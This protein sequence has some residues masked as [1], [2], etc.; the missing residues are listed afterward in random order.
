M[1]T[2]FCLAYRT[3][4]FGSLCISLYPLSSTLLVYISLFYFHSLYCILHLAG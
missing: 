1:S 2:V 3:L 4:F